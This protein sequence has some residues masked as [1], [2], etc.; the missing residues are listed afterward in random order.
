LIP[1]D[2]KFQQQ[3]DLPL[4]HSRMSLCWCET[5]FRFSTTLSGT[6]PASSTTANPS[7]IQKIYIVDHSFNSLTLCLVSGLFSLLDKKDKKW[8]AFGTDADMEP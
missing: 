3:Q 7:S 5:F 1:K 4:I 8:R 2:T 6:M